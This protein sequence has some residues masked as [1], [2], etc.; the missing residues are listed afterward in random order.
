MKAYFLFTVTGPLVILTSHDSIEHP[1]LLE[2][3]LSKGFTKFIAYEVSIESAKAKYGNHFNVVCGD[4]LQSDD[5]RV[6]ACSE[7]ALANWSFKELGTPTYH[8]LEPA[9]TASTAE[10]PEKTVRQTR[11]G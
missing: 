4:R 3:L 2:K 10:R 7:R 8:E 6:L 1:E 11:G 9:H 5:L